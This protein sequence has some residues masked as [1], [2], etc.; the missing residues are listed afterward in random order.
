[1]LDVSNRMREIR[2][3]AFPSVHSVVVHNGADPIPRDNFTHPRPPEI[4]DRLVVCCVSIWYSR[5]G[6]PKLV[7][8]FSI[9]AKDFPNAVLRLIGDGPDRPA[10]TAAIET[11]PAPAQ[12]QVLGL[13]SHERAMQEMCWG[14]LYALIG[15]DEPFA[16]TFTEAMMAGLPLIWP[17]DCGHN[18]VLVDGV[19][20]ERVP[21]LDVSAT[22]AALRKLL[23]DAELRRTIGQANR[24]YAMK[25]L[26][27]DANATK[28]ISLFSKASGPNP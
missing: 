23:S 15:K 25:E 8:A 20:G 19:H 13:Q 9:I 7:E 10:V 22:A 18:D 28:M 16:T 24:D 26:T 14:D 3:K 21:P 6:I 12:I 1:M 2:R 17:S 27:W 11:S 5:K 4:V